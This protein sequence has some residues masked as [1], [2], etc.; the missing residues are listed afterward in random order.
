MDKNIIW[1]DQALK[2]QNKS[3][4]ALGRAIGVDP[5][6]VTRIFQG[7]R[8]IQVDEWKK[9]ISWLG[10]QPPSFPLPDLTGGITMGESIPVVGVIMERVWQEGARRQ[11]KRKEV[12]AI[13]SADYPP[14]EQYALEVDEESRTVGTSAEFVVCVPFEKMR[15]KIRDGDRLHCERHRDGLT[16][17]VLRRAVLKSGSGFHL[18]GPNDAD[19]TPIDDFEIKGLVIGRQERYVD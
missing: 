17:V 2:N 3:R 19:T 18:V 11:P 1:L 15:R 10:K 4:A 12:A 16:Q 6:S 9:I 14:S 8:R 7:R 13:P 5:G